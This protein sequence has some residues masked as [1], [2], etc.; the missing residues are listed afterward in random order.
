MVVYFTNISYLFTNIGFVAL[1]VLFYFKLKQGFRCAW[2]FVF[3]LVH[4]NSSMF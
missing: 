2:A 1:L 4:P 3:L